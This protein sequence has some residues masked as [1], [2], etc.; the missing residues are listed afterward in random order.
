VTQGELS[1]R[2]FQAELDRQRR[3]EA[4]LM[5]RGVAI[6]VAVALLVTLRAIVL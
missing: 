2:E 3:S 5:L 1:E 6:L 4:L